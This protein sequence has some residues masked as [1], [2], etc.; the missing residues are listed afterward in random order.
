LAVGG[1]TGGVAGDGPAS[2]VED[3]EPAGID[4]RHRVVVDA[5]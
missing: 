5:A 4:D 2:A 3:P 1:P